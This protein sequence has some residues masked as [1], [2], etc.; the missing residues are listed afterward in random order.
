MTNEQVASLLER[1]EKLTTQHKPLFGLMDV[2]QMV[3][4]CTDQIRVALGTKIL[5]E[6]AGVDPE[7]II[8]LAKAGKQVPTPKGLGQREGE[9][10]YPTLLAADKETLKQHLIRFARLPTDFQLA[11]HPYFGSIDRARWNS[12]VVYHL[13]HH[14]TQ[15]GV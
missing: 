12:L 4:H 8:A 5:P 10:T 1:I 15:F 9:G 7:K 2:S 6:Q 13:N 3:C 14:L 11:A